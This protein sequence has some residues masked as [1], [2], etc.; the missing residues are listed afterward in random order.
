MKILEIVYGLTSGGAERFVVDLSNELSKTEEVTLLVLKDV[1]QFYAPQVDSKVHLEFAKLPVGSTLRQ[2][3]YVI[4]YIKKLKPEVVH[5]HVAARYS[6][7]PANILLRNRCKFFMT[8][9]SDVEKAYSKG[10]SGWQVRMAYKL[11]GC[12]YIT[13][14]KENYNQFSRIYPNYP[15]RMIV[16]GRAKPVLSANFH[17]VEEEMGVLKKDKDTSVYIHVAR[18]VPVKN[19][20]LLVEAFCKHVQQGANAILLVI[21]DGFDTELGK[22][23]RKLACPEIHFLGT[24]QNVYDYLS[25][26]DAFCLSSLYE[27]MPIS[28]IEAVLSGLPI[29]STPVSGTIDAIVDGGNGYITK[30]FEV[31]SY[32]EAFGLFERNKP[33]LKANANQSKESNAFGIAYCAEQYLEWFNN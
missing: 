16:N 11:G 13:I 5:Y 28:V 17:K 1:E 27:G 4:Q 21:G 3:T 10:V 23:L 2:F 7:L 33:T 20:K 29:I 22:E 25:C 14:S 30:D 8:I 9:H 18:C 19:Q 32:L 15:V 24:R 31:E 12:K 6:C 26:A